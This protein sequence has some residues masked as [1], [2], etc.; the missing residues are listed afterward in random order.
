MEGGENMNTFNL[1]APISTMFS[2]KVDENNG[3]TMQANS[4]MEVSNTFDPDSVNKDAKLEAMNYTVSTGGTYNG[5]YWPYWEPY[6]EYYHTCYHAVTTPDRFETAFK[7]AR[8]LMDKKQVR[9]MKTVED[10]FKLMDVI[11][12]AL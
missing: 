3:T 2:M 12:E 8:K 11:V 7:L 10:F 6:R 1:D 4:M 5:Y 9:P